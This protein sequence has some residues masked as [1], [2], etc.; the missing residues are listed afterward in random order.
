MQRPGI[1]RK[2]NST[3]FQKLEKEREILPRFGETRRI[4]SKK[5]VY[6]KKKYDFRFMIIMHWPSEA[7]VSLAKKR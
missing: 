5:I 4:E 3:G 2:R 6:A 7:K 1:L